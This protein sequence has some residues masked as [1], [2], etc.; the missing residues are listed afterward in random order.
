MNEPLLA[1]IP[2]L[3]L[4]PTYTPDEWHLMQTLRERYRQDRDLFSVAERARLS[5]V[6]WLVRTGRLVP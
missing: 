2:R 6:R 5:F 1:P 4:I 3:V